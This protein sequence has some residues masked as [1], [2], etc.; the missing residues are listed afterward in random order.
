MMI[1]LVMFGATSTALVI[2]RGLAWWRGTRWRRVL[3]Q[4]EKLN[5]R[6]KQ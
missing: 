2:D 4:S 1:L 3:R 6:N 5:R